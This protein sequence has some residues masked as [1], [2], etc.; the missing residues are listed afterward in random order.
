[1][2]TEYNGEAYKLDRGS[3]T[4]TC[5]GQ[6]FGAGEKGKTATVFQRYH[7]CLDLGQGAPQRLVT[8]T[9]CRSQNFDFGVGQLDT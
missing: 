2:R 4:A 5:G 3:S 7:E 8:R 9:T 1:M 6:G